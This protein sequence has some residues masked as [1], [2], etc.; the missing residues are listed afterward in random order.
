VTQQSLLLLRGRQQPE[1]RHIRTVIVNTDI[2]S[3]STPAAVGVAGPGLKS[4]VYSQR[5]IR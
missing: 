4:R 2:P 1:P 5:R 3:G